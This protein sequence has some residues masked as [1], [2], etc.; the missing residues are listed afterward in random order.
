MSPCRRKDGRRKPGPSALSA[1]WLHRTSTPSGGNDA[2]T[3]IILV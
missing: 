1:R 2:I 3:R